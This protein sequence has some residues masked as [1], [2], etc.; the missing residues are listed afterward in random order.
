MGI[1][2]CVLHVDYYCVKILK[3]G[4]GN[5]TNPCLVLSFGLVFHIMLD[6]S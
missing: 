3:G 6:F 5:V 2:F 4:G 1:A